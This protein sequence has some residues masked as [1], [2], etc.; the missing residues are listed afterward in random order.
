MAIANVGM[1]K[2]IESWK[3]KKSWKSPHLMSYPVQELES[4]ELNNVNL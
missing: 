2:I 1:D 3:K 4:S